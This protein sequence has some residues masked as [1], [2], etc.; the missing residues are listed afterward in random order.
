MSSSSININN[1]FFEGVYKHAWKGTIP[2][3][4]TEAEA[5]FIQEIASLKNGGK[6][7]DIMC[8]YGRHA[9]ELG[10]RGVQVTAIDNLRDY[11]DEIKEKAKEKSLPIS[12]IQEDILYAK[13][14]EVYDA[15]I[16]MGNSFAFFD[17]NDA[18]T[19]LQNISNHIK[20]GGVLIINSW[21]VAEVA[22][23]HFKEKDWH[24][25]GEYKC[26]LEYKYSFHP[27]RIESEQTIVAPDRSI[28]IVKGVD[29]IFTLDEME[30][31]FNDAGFKTTNVFSTPRKKKFV[32]GDGRVY[33]VAA[34]I[35]E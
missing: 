3:G 26:M 32:I 18:I 9:L 28:E 11:I 29:Y 34:K 30:A 14:D 22:I 8:G 10:R 5:D 7:L 6:V 31:M 35:A 2:P 21:M 33:I 1:T 27:S 23:K 16:C 20:P 25:A 15:A 17:R 24:Y 13:L 4:L 19:I 12:A